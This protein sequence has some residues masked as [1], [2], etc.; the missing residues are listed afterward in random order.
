M[1]QGYSSGMLISTHFFGFDI[2][3]FLTLFIILIQIDIMNYFWLLKIIN[4]TLFRVACWCIKNLSFFCEQKKAKISREKIFF[5]ENPQ[6]WPAAQKTTKIS[7]Y[8]YYFLASKN[9]LPKKTNYSFWL[10]KSACVFTCF[11]SVYEWILVLLFLF[12]LY[13]CLSF[14]TIF[15]VFKFLWNAKMKKKIPCKLLEKTQNEEKIFFFCFFKKECLND[16][17][18]NIWIIVFWMNEMGVTVTRT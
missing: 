2:P 8:Y 16:S 12:F 1:V 13:T 3:L 7:Y 4:F 14:T 17:R 15:F 11:F 9:L 6:L 5:R 18:H 10:K